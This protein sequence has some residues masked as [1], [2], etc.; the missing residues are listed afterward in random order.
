MI[1]ERRETDPAAADLSRAACVIGVGAGIGDPSGL[2]LVG[3]L[4]RRLGAA[5]GGT[6]KVCDLGWL[7]RQAQ[8]GLTGQSIAPALYIALGVRGGLNHSIGLVRAGRIVAINRDPAAPIFEHAD[9]GLAGDWAVLVSA[10]IAELD[11]RP[12]RGF[13]SPLVS[14]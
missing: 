12:L 14:A 8:I 1:R 7:P 6:R 11:A 2:E 5:I 10:L 13:A 9:Y 4:A 3:E